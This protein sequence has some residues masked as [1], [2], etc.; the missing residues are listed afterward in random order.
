MA[1]AKFERKKPHVNIGTI[2]HVDHGKTSLTAAIT[3]VLAQKGLAKKVAYDEIDNA[4]EEKAR[5]ITINIS[6]QEYETDSRHYAHVDCPGHADFIKNMITGA[7]QMDGAILVV[8]ATDGPMPQ[9]REHILLARQVGVPHIVVFINK[10]DLVDDEELIELVEMEVRDLLSK[11]GFPGDDTPIL[12]GSAVKVLEQL[13]KGTLD[14]ADPYVK[15]VTDLMEAVDTF[16]PTPTRDKDKAFLM[17]VEDVFTITGRGTVA[18]GRVERGQ[19]KSMAEVEIIGLQAESRKTV[20]TGIEMF[21]KTLDYCEAGD[22]VGLLL[23]GVDR[24]SI[25]RGQ[26]VAKPG[27][28]TPHRKFKAEVYVLSKDEG[29]RHTPFVTGYRPQFFFRTT[30][31]TGTLELPNGIEMVMPG[32]NVTMTIELIEGKP[33]AMEQGSKFAIREGGRT[34]GAGTITEIVS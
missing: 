1:R 32:D 30:D 4:P 11:Y 34:V 29:G 21:R 9:T 16:I 8:S 33:V 6:H 25:E 26:V 13:E 14:L 24:T 12:K 28:I 19:L 15:A 7:A 10:T 18:T 27:S 17:A 5:G 22:N 23:R 20:C 2:G 31:V 3:G